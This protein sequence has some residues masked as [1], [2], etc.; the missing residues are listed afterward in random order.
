MGIGSFFKDYIINP[1][2]E[3]LSG[4]KKETIS[5]QE[6]RKEA[7]DRRAKREAEERVKTK[8]VQ[9]WKPILEQLPEYQELSPK[10]KRNVLKAVRDEPEKFLKILKQTESYQKLSDRAKKNLFNSLYAP[11][12][13]EGI[14]DFTKKNPIP[15]KPLETPYID[16]TG[17]VG[18]GVALGL[19]AVPGIIAGDI[20]G[21]T[22]K[23]TATK[24]FGDN[25]F[26][27]DILPV[28]MDIASGMAGAKV[29]DKLT[30]TNKAGFV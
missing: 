11:Y 8:R 14:A 23:Q 18:G 10:G 27:R 7:S 29:Y 19:K 3:A 15:E 16:P 22:T 26:T 30:K 20:V 1:A 21:E 4:D 28:A 6:I 24:V 13:W 12:D 25:T 9:V 17:W 5:M 2:K